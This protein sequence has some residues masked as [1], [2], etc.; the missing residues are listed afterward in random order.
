[1]SF[2]R[3]VCAALLTYSLG[4][5]SAF[6]AEPISL[7]INNDALPNLIGPRPVI[8]TAWVD[9]TRQ[10]GSGG[11]WFR[12]KVDAQGKVTRAKLLSGAAERRKEA[13]HAAQALRFKP[14]VVDG[15]PAPVQF[16]FLIQAS[17]DDYV[18]PADRAFPTQVE[19]SKVRVALLRTE[20]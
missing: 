19:P 13:A 2:S 10:S 1:M 17:N 9:L 3:P 6:A 8:R 18:G 14:F 16:D 15:K 20:S 12:L 7:Q 11:W 4:A 5:A